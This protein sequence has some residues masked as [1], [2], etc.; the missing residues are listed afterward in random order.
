MNE[1]KQDFLDMKLVGPYL[2]SIHQHSNYTR[3]V[4]FIERCVANL[5]WHKF[6]CP[7]PKPLQRYEL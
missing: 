5:N 2:Y 1:I 7:E 4:K 6:S 3:N